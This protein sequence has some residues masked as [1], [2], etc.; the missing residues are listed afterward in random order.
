MRYWSRGC[1]ISVA[2]Y[3]RRVVERARS[4]L[5]VLVVPHRVDA[6]RTAGYGCEPEE[7]QSESE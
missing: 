2:L 7:R 6:S 1:F 5:V 3:H 4:T